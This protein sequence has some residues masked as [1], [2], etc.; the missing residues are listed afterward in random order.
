MSTAT[1]RYP[2]KG[3]GNEPPERRAYTNKAK[4]CGPVSQTPSTSSISC[5]Q[6]GITGVP[7]SILS[8][9]FAKAWRLLHMK[10]V[11]DGFQHDNTV[12]VV[13]E[14]STKPHVVTEYTQAYVITHWQPR[15]TRVSFKCYAGKCNQNVHLRL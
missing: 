1:S 6:S 4:E 14:T 3:R 7:E 11:T 8:N 12:L 13:S 9:L 2:Q 5:K 15:N 10:R